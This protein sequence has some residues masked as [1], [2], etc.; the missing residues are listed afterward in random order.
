MQ[1]KEIFRNI[2]SEFDSVK[3]EINHAK[4]F[5]EEARQFFGRKK[6]GTGKNKAVFTEQMS[7]IVKSSMYEIERI[8]NMQETDIDSFVLYKLRKSI[9]NLKEKM[10]Y[11]NYIEKL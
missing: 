7:V 11:I 5:L 6:K 9:E 2:K 8:T 1:Q 3:S 4:L 10:D